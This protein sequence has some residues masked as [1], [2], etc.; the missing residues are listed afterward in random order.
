MSANDP[1]DYVRREIDWIEIRYAR[2]GRFW[3][4][5]WAPRCWR[6]NRAQV[7]PHQEGRRGVG[8]YPIRPTAADMRSARTG[9]STSI[10]G[11]AR[12]FSCL[13]VRKLLAEGDD[14]PVQAFQHDHA[15]APVSSDV[16]YAMMHRWT[17]RGCYAWIAGAHPRHLHFEGRR[18]MT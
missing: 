14:F 10:T 2:T 17:T 5:A 8:Y 4:F 9:P 1:D 16:T 3:A 15:F 18:S 12:A 7:A 6:S 13:A 11:T